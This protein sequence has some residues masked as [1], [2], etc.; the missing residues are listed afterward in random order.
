MQYTIL[1]SEQTVNNSV[2]NNSFGIKCCIGYKSQYS[3]IIEI[4]KTQ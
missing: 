1:V 3:S 2:E 4:L